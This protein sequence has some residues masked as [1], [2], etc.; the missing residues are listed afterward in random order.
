[1]G[2]KCFSELLAVPEEG[3][4]EDLPFDIWA[5]R[6]FGPTLAG[7][8]MIPYNEKLSARDLGEMEIS[9]TSWSVPVPSAAELK[10]IVRGEKPPA[11]GYNA[12]FFYPDHGGIEI[13]PRSLAHGQEDRLR[14]GEC[15]TRIDAGG[16]VVTLQDGQEF[17]YS[18]LISTIPLPELLS[19]A[20]GLPDGLVRSAG[21]LRKSSVLGVCLGLDGPVLRSDHWIYFPEKSLP[22]YRMGFPSNFSRNVAPAGCGS[23]YAEA[24]W[25]DGQPPEPDSIAEAVLESM[26]A[27]GLID[28]SVG[29][30]ARADL[31]IEYAYV[32]H[33]RYR[34]AHLGSILHSLR[35]K[36]ILSIGRYGAWE[37]S[38][39]QD[40][41]QWG[42]TAAREVLN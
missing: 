33:D 40:A 38:A 29:I 5:A 17:T 21:S 20:H 30:R 37:Y 15:V 3:V 9:W 24:A 39:M 19:N 6:R 42:L 14:T 27:A 13:L 22:F 11:F 35:E 16:K 7:L 12:M 25:S 4:S 31:A 36:D 26:A 32:F 41:V 23:I 28:R 8:F 2:E 34:A 10:A 1:M 18:T